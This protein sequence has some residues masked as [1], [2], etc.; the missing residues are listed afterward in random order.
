MK[1]KKILPV[2]AIIF[3]L[4]ACS[5]PGDVTVQSAI[6]A[7]SDG[8]YEKSLALF[9]QALDE[10]RNYSD[11]LIYNFMGTVYQAQDDLEN[12]VIYQ[13]KALSVR[14]EYRGLVTLGMNFHTLGDDQ[15][16]KEF[17]KEAI[18]LDPKKGEA[19]ASLGA[20][21]LLKGDADSA[22]DYFEQG[23]KNDPKI[24]VIHANLAVAYAMQKKSD[25]ALSE[26]KKAEELKC[27]N[28]DS[29]RERVEDLLDGSQTGGKK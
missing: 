4:S 29:F 1:L 18:N 22:A 26:L 24:A 11:E 16:A 23:I 12:A 19:Y 20:L 13:E 3:S 2:F 8:D 28:I 27:E 17:Y 6:R 10:S 21:Y 5:R 14:P 7:Y 9:T 25:A 15:K